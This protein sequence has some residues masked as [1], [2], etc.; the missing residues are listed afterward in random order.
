MKHL[1]KLN[2]TQRLCKLFIE[3]RHVEQIGVETTDSVGEFVSFGP[4]STAR[5]LLQKTLNGVENE[6][7][8]SGNVHLLL[9]FVEELALECGAAAATQ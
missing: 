3:L 7:L 2:T 6:R 4:R 8:D 9:E 1:L 5:V